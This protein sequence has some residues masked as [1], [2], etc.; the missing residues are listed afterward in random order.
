MFASKISFT[1]LATALAILFLLAVPSHAQTFTW[2]GA[3]GGNWSDSS[4]WDGGNIAPDTNA[5]GPYA[6]V[7]FANENDQTV[8]MDRVATS[9][10]GYNI[11]GF[12]FAAGVG[13]YILNSSVPTAFDM[14]GAG[15][16]SSVTN[17]STNTQTINFGLIGRGD[18]TSALVFDTAAGDIIVNGIITHIGASGSVLKTGSE[19]LVLNAAS[20]YKAITIINEGVLQASILTNGNSDSSIGSSTADSANLVFNGG[21]LHYTGAST[22]TNRGFTLDTNGGTLQTNPGEQLTISGVIVGDGPLTIAENSI[23]QLNSTASTFTGPVHIN[24]GA[25]LKLNTLDNNAA[26][27]PLGATPPVTDPPHDDATKIQFHGGTLDYLSATARGTSYGITLHEPGGT[28]QTIVGSGI[29][30]DG[31]V[32]GT[33]PLN[34]GGAGY[35]AFTNNLNDY[36]G[37][38]NV[39]SGAKLEVRKANV[40]G[41]A[42]ADSNTIVHSGAIIEFNPNGGFGASANISIAEYITVHGGGIVRNTSRTNTL[43]NTLTLTGDV[44]FNIINSSNLITSSGKLVSSHNIL[45]TGNGTLSLGSSNTSFSGDITIQEGRVSVASFNALGTSTNNIILDGGIFRYTGTAYALERGFTLTSNGGTF[46]N[47]APWRL[48]GIITGDGPLTITNSASYVA[49]SN[50]DSD[51]TGITTINAGASLYLRNSNVLGATGATSSTEVYGNLVVDSGGSGGVA[52]T[53][54]IDLH[55]TLNFYNG[56]TLQ[57]LSRNNSISGP[58]SL[59]DGDTRLNVAANTILTLNSAINGDGGFTLDNSA[60]TKNGRVILNKTNTYSGPTTLNNG[61]FQVGNGGVGSI[62]STTEVQLPATLSGTGAVNAQTNLSGILS[63]GDNGGSDIGT[64]TLGDLA[65]KDGS[66]LLFKFTT[67]DTT[68]ASLSE[69]DTLTDPT[70]SGLN[71][72][73]FISNTL[74]SD[75]DAV[76]NLQLDFTGMTLAEGQVFDLFDAT[77]FAFSPNNSYNISIIGATLDPTNMINTSRFSDLGVLAVTV[78]PEPSRALLLLGSLAALG[79]HRRRR[80]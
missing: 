59:V 61:N 71:D 12:T 19:T 65:L 57:N 70:Q 1:S 78:V 6:L 36:T 45:K 2:T 44:E 76:I 58:V 55:E 32:S 66:T 39:L 63:P 4:N 64:L 9:G 15:G 27:G 8:D 23:V 56:S 17:L 51:Y 79:F 60:D 80:R 5:P 52:G 42:D 69:L 25:V 24:N 74:S 43:T 21:T 28:I 37:V 34:I 26:T 49:F 62:A 14:L 46:D 53:G 48:A 29:R 18:F 11:N 75:P 30:W 72:F 40:L 16:T 77:T 54:T 68:I 50:N 35:V 67:A 22:S 7:I 13:A 31:K 10:G 20:S 47:A 3:T 41:E 33:G 38:T 73:A